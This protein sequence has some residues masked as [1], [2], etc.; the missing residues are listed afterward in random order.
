MKFIN[1]L[2]LLTLLFFI[3]CAKER[4]YEV[5][6][7]DID[8]LS[9]NALPVQFK[10]GA[11][12]N[13]GGGTGSSARS[14]FTV[15]D[16]SQLNR[17]NDI[18]YVASAQGIPRTAVGFR[19]YHQGKEKVIQLFYEEDGI[20]GYEMEKDGN[21]I[22]NPLNNKPVIKIPV[23]Y[24]SYRCRENANDECTNIEEVNNDANVEWYQK[25]RINIKYD[26]VDLLEYDYTTL[27]NS[28]YS[29]TRSELIH[30]EVNK[31][32]IYFEVK[33]TLKWNYMS[34]SCIRWI[35]NQPRDWDWRGRLLDENAAIEVTASFS[36]MRLNKVASANYE[37]IKYPIHDHQRFGFF[38]SVDHYKKVNQDHEMDY[39]LNR[40][41]PDKNNG[42][43]TYYLSREFNKPINKYLKDATIKAF[44]QMN[45]TLEYTGVKLRLDLK[46][47]TPDL[48]T[49]I[50]PGDIR[51][52]MVVLIED[53]ASGLLGYGPSVANPY[54]G[55]IVK[56]HTNMYKGSLERYAPYVYDNL[57]EL[58]ALDA[59]RA[60]A[61]LPPTAAAPAGSPTAQATD[62]KIRF[63]EIERMFKQSE[64]SPLI[65]FDV[66][67]F[68]QYS[69]FRPKELKDI[70]INP[71]TVLP[72]IPF[73]G[74]GQ[75]LD[76]NAI[77]EFQTFLK[78]EFKFTNP[79]NLE[80]TYARM[81]ELAE[82][83]FENADKSVFGNSE[84]LNIA[85]ILGPAAMEA[86]KSLELIDEYSR[87]NIYTVEMMNFDALGKE[88]IDSIE[89]VEGIRNASGKLKPW[90]S[91]NE[92]QQRQLTEIL[93]VHYYIPTLVHE[94]GH[95]LGL[96]HNFKGSNDI[97]NFYN[98]R[99][100]NDLGLVGAARYSS[101]MDYNYS[102]LN[103]LTTFGKY[104]TSALKFAYN[105]EVELRDGSQLKVEKDLFSYLIDRNI[106]PNIKRYEFCTDE[107]A[108]TSMTCDRFDEG[109]N[110]LEIANHFI[111]RYINRYKYSNVKDRKETFN[112]YGNV[113]FL[114]TQYI[115]MASMRRIHEMWQAYYK[116]LAR[117]TQPGQQNMAIVGCP[118]EMRQGGAADFCNDLDMVLEA[119]MNAGRFFLDIIK[120]PQLTCHVKLNGKVGETQV[121]NNIY[122]YIP[123]ST[124]DIQSIRIPL[125]NNKGYT[126]PTSCFHDEVQTHL[127]RTAQNIL[128]SA[129]T[130]GNPNAQCGQSID[131]TVEIIGEAG[132]PLNDIRAATRMDM[133]TYTSDLE[134]RGLWMEKMLAAHFLTHRHNII[135]AGGDN[136]IGFV[137]HPV[138]REEIINLV[139]HLAYG[140][141]LR[142]NITF[143]GKNGS[144]YQ[145]PFLD[146]EGNMV[147]AYTSNLND[148]ISV[149]PYTHDYL[150][151][152][153]K[154]PKSEDSQ[155]GFN[156]AP[157]LLRQIS[158]SSMV[159]TSTMENNPD[160]IA[161]SK[162]L[163]NYITAY[164]QDD[165]YTGKDFGANVISQ[166]NFPQLNRKIGATEQNGL[167][168]HMI[169]QL[170]GGRAETNKKIMD[171]VEKL[172]APP[173]EAVDTTTQAGIEAAS[174]ARN[175][176]TKGTELLQTVYGY[177]SLHERFF[178]E[179]QAL[180]FF[181]E[182]A[183]SEAQINQILT[184]LAADWGQKK[185]ETVMYVFGEMTKTASQEEATLR[186]MNIIDL[187]YAVADAA[188]KAELDEKLKTGLF[189]LRQNGTR[190]FSIL[191]FYRFNPESE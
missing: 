29:E 37:P 168:N 79:K 170:S 70:D 138:F 94:I 59:R 134:I 83:A 5:E 116:F 45:D 148:K 182:N 188:G 133:K 149:P 164:W 78:D 49:K 99:E 169:T 171:I 114:I 172:N 190:D 25:D 137:D 109:T 9:V 23:D 184:M 46:E 75:V 17:G 6:E 16:Q 191:F 11:G 162:Q 139:Q 71:P 157:Y 34:W 90:M 131:Y 93:V 173:A 89:V 12:N 178:T 163:H 8:E 147:P 1:V 128:N 33:K 117:F 39:Y 55:E 76:A 15:L 48:E 165:V 130:Q 179:I 38:T 143:K 82:E 161:R 120:T 2:F 18:L 95:N 153:I 81:N 101:I 158:N 41:N 167:A 88:G 91:L 103:G 151:W 53:I 108:G 51:Y 61:N 63:Q 113:S 52:S 111:E 26:Q 66:N 187:Q 121:W 159:E 118:P 175:P 73:Q 56:A 77:N 186:D 132:K 123:L 107:N 122:Q 124:N 22:D 85:G 154:F 189:N 86:Q 97:A 145:T 84:T 152:F 19:P 129:C 127:D 31:D 7:K 69:N 27:N 100:R 35:F 105:R 72:Q 174:Q 150:N 67:R 144:L 3:G 142:S 24:V 181:A 126:H 13:Q 160:S 185:F 74:G 64:L 42:V 119:N 43:V 21:F 40:F 176:G 50:R 156:L 80:H 125:E 136:H 20:V 30:H 155:D 87:N 10:P 68:D 110:T 58:E 115:R 28:C 4:P 140:Q 104:D 65:G 146:D 32:M 166:F 98:E 44:K 102:S 141:P 57:R 135:T 112:E 62:S 92:R 177:R 54:T 36:M 14:Q 60:A 106:G 47:L 96:R 180:F 183:Q